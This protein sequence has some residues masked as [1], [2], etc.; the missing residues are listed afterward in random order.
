MSSY[1]PQF[2]ADR[3]SRVLRAVSDP[4]EPSLSIG[5]LADATGV[6]TGTLRIWETR[7]GFPV[8]TRLASGHRRYGDDDV[9]AVRLV[10]A[11]RDSGVRL[12]VAIA[13]TLNAGEEVTPPS[14]SVFARLRQTH[15]TLLPARLTKSTLLAMSWAIEDEF[16]AQAGRGHVFGAFQ[17]EH[18]YNSARARWTDIAR[19]SSSTFVFADF[20]E[21][22]DGSPT[23]VPLAPDAPMIREW[24]VVCDAPTMSVALTAWELPGQSEV[25]DSERVFETLWTVDPSAVREAAQVC[26]ALAAEAGSQR[27][28]AVVEELS[29]PLDDHNFDIGALTSLFN[30]S[31][32]Y[33][34]AAPRN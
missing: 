34:D 19:V 23:V 7:H 5:D 20:A 4:H 24:A 21:C 18:R 27:A 11:L 32:S 33:V 31:V 8:P 3:G 14:E 22:V 25:R 9:E 15:P 2:K 28:V 6:S 30:R 16:C 12:D 10:A 17:E 1:S 13:R 29:E 26:A